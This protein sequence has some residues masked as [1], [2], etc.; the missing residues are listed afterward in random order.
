MG[1]R[2]NPSKIFLAVAL[3]LA[4]AIAALA[5]YGSLRWPWA[6]LIGV[7][8]AT[9]ILYGY[10]KSISGGKQ[11]RIPEAVLHLM[12]LVG[13][14]PGAFLGQHLFRHKVSKRPFQVVFWLTVGFQLALV[15]AGLW[16]WKHPPSWL[17]ESLTR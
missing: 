10:D 8:G 1:E 15:A 12:S 9:L 2:V 13:G 11:L 17:P 7:N 3:I 4:G 6:I 16:M 14:S 5:A